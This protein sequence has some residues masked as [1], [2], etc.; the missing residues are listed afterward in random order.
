MKHELKKVAPWTVGKVVGLLYAV[1]TLLFVPFSLLFIGVGIFGV[2]NGKTEAAGAIVMGVFFLFAPVIYGG[3][4]F[5]F[6]ALM[7][8]IYN[9]V[10]GKV[11]GIVFETVPKE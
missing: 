6:G 10:A 3:L 1:F 5:L 11:G 2:A 4:G 7:A 9:L 8:W